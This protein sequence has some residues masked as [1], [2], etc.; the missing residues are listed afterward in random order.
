M[1]K[2]SVT[3]ARMRMAAIRVTL[4]TSN[5]CLPQDQRLKPYWNVGVFGP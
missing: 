3:K 5:V 1:G 2:D 4:F